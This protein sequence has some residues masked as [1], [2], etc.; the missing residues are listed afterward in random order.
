[1][2][3]TLL[4]IL[5]SVYKLVN[6]IMRKFCGHHVAAPQLAEGIELSNGPMLGSLTMCMIMPLRYFVDAS[7]VLSIPN[8]SYFNFSRFI[9][10]LP[11][12]IYTMSNCISKSINL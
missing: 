3:I 6:L 11:I 5:Y 1:M 8:F 10:L 9:D 7:I 12:C 4:S 2:S